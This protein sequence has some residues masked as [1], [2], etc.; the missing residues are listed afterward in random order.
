MDVHG[1]DAG[2]ITF[3]Q[4]IAPF[5]ADTFFSAVQGRKWL[6]VPGTPEKAAP[7]FS[8]DDL[9]AI[10]N[11]DVWTASVVAIMLDGQRAPP[12][13][14]CRQTVNRNKHSVMQP[15]AEKVMALLRQSASMVLDDITSLAP[16]VG[17]VVEM[18]MRTFHA[19]ATCNLYFSQRQRQAFNS[20]FDR[21]DVFA[22]QIYGEKRWRVYRGRAD[23]PIENPRYYN[24]LQSEYD[25]VKGELD[26]EVTMRPGD[27]LYLPRGLCHDAMAITD[28][29]LH[30]TF[31]CVL[32]MGL[33]L[34]QDM[35]R[36]LIEESLFRADLPRL[37]AEDGDQT[38]R[39]HLET[40][41]AR[42]M[43][44]Y[45]GE[46]GLELARSIIRDF[47][48]AAA[49]SFDLSKL[50]S[51][52]AQPRG[53]TRL[54]ARRAGRSGAKSGRSRQIAVLGHHFLVS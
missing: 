41:L 14:Y 10:L 8:S 40:L 18:L 34:A 47:S 13:A 7:I 49:A 33:H 17:Q 20:H 9:N 12:P 16:A 21:H 44:L 54:G 39:K 22:L 3:A 46:H 35:A 36:R 32:P 26:Q 1:D 29:S 27:L 42:L 2:A 43:E 28:Q 37:D 30:L 19:Q 52:Q 23:N 6:H 4:L 50:K 11:M 25:R 45:S 31:S 51:R 24:I 53:A 48:G 38:L 15:D 5:D